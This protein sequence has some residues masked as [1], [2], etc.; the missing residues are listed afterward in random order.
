[1]ARVI[2]IN[3]YYREARGTTSMGIITP[4]LGLAYMASVLLK[5]S[6]KVQIIDA[7]LLDIRSERITD[8][9]LFRPDIV[10]ISNSIT[11]YKEAVRCAEKIKPAYPDASVLFGGPHSS[12]LAQTVL[13]RNASVD[14]V[15]VGEGENTLKEIADSAGKRNIFEGIKGIAYRDR[16]R[17]VHN[18]PRPLIDNIDDIPLPAYHLLPH[19][20]K[21][22][23]RSRAWPVGYIITSR[24]CPSRCT[25]CCRN[26]GT[27]WRPHSAGRVIGEIRHLIKEYKIRQIDIL[28]DNFTFDIKR[29]AEILDLLTQEGLGIKVNLQNGVRVDRINEELLLKM[30]KAGVFKIAF[31]IESGDPG[32]LKKIKKGV[33]LDKAVLL[34]KTARSLGMV[35]HGYFIIGLPGDTKETIERTIDFS[36][37]MNPHYASF[38]ICTPLP[39]TEIFD[40]IK[41]KG[42]LLEDVEDGIDAGLFSLKVFFRPDN[43]TPQEVSYLC[44]KTWK[45]FYMR[46][47]KILDVLSTTKSL[48]EFR[49]LARIAIDILRTE[50]GK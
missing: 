50:S 34:V 20:T 35:T 14:A 12:A 10:G 16:E 17:I 24:G 13:E 46:P 33:D 30:K 15:V 43:L 25:F 21:Y 31:G 42:A 8:N 9:F 6:H 1:M 40:E 5:N 7:N 44:E 27:S 29:A 32:I 3:P 37:R 38:S 41:R 28:D 47:S 11:S 18:E 22:R 19:L 26:F 45:K 23:S 4:P 39:G 48:G 49:W 36:L 2:L